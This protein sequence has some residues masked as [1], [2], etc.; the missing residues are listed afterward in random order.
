MKKETPR[1]YQLTSILCSVLSFVVIAYSMRGYINQNNLEVGDFAANSLLVQQAKEHLLLFGN[2][3]RVGFNHPGPAIIYVLAAGEVILFDYLKLVRSA[4]SG[5]LVAVALYNSIWIVL[6]WRALY[7]SLGRIGAAAASLCVFLLLSALLDHQ[8]FGGIWFPHLYFFPFCLVLF[9][10][11]V[12]V[13]GELRFLPSFALACGVLFNGHVSFIPFLSFFTLLLV[14]YTFWIEGRAPSSLINALLARGNAPV[15]LCSC[16]IVLFFFLPLIILTI[17]QFPGPLASYASFGGAHKTN[18]LGPSI[19]FVSVYWG[20]VP[21]MISALLSSVLLFHVRKI[22]G[23][24]PPEIRNAVAVVGAATLA[25]LFYAKYGIDYLNQEYIGEYYY[26]VPAFLGCF[27]FIAASAF[28]SNRVRAIFDICIAVLCAVIVFSQ[29]KK[30]VSYDFAYN[31]PSAAEIHNTL[32]ALRAPKK[33]ALDLIDTE[34][35]GN[36]W[37]TILGAQ[38]LA[39]RSK[40]GQFCINRGWHISFTLAARCSPEE[41][42]SGSR[43]IVTAESTAQRPKDDHEIDVGGLRIIRRLPPSLDDKGTITVAKSPLLF[44]DYLLQMGWSPVQSDF[45]WTTADEAQLSLPLGQN[46]SGDVLLDM[47]AYLPQADSTQEVQLVDDQGHAS[48]ALFSQ[49]DNRKI[50]RLHILQAAGNPVTFTLKIKAPIVPSALGLG[51]D[52]RRLGVSLYGL[53]IVSSRQ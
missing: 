8:V 25:L 42:R 44:S 24:L 47:A 20:G 43:Y 14:G 7:F 46:F 39:E 48:T 26:A 4:F 12:I 13:R 38:I 3:S 5:Q 22:R 11:S 49:A 33:L 19:H 17:S 10:S 53:E 50:I 1:Y 45:V 35:W 31:Q 41:L 27:T 32:V 36:V 40:Q 18:S 2:Y 37:S 52:Q 6:I 16:A 9:S 51:R 28:V 15:V 23:D 30:P 21:A 29:I 34:D